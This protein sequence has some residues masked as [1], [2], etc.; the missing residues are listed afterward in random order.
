MLSVTR[1]RKKAGTKIPHTAKQRTPKS[2]S[3][4]K[5]ALVAYLD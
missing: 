4:L 2:Y 1:P 5:E 3:P